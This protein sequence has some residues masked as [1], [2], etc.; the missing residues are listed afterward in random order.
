MTLYWIFS[1]NIL[2][3]GLTQEDAQTALEMF[4]EQKGLP[5]L[6]IEDYNC[7]I[8]KKIDAK[9]LLQ[10]HDELLFEVPNEEKDIIFEIIIGLYL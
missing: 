6:E 4:R 5:N 7:I 2:C 9:M 1:K 10:V 3:D 8:F